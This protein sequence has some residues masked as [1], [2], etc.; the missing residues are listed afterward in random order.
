M[1]KLLDPHDD[2]VG[3][4]LECAVRYALGRKTYMGSVVTGVISS[5][6]PDLNNKTLL[7]M[8]REIVKHERFG[9]GGDIDKKEWISLRDTLRREIDKRN[10]ER[11]K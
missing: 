7:L 8:E 5:V 2:N 4:V 3:A 11:W 9:Y 6:V 1:S 10:L